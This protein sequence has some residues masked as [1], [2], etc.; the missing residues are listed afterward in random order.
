MT[1][2]RS[3]TN[4]PTPRDSANTTQLLY[5]LRPLNVTIGYV[6]NS[7]WKIVLLLCTEAL[8]PGIHASD[9]SSFIIQALVSVST[10]SV[11]VVMH[12]RPVP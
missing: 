2:K 9:A 1:S 12:L 3:N 6:N 5:W 11:G 10:N 8:I 4:K 7:S